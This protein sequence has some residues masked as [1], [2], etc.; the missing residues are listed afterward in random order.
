MY[1]KARQNTHFDN[2]QLAAFEILTVGPLENE[3]DAVRRQN[4][5]VAAVLKEITL[6]LS[7]IFCPGIFLRVHLNLGKNK[8]VY[9]EI[10]KLN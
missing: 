8:K 4:E 1:T 7:S 6:N 2:F 9:L 3:T 10:K 5:I